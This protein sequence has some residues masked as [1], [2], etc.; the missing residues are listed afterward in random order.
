MKITGISKIQR[1]LII[2]ED[3]TYFD[4]KLYH[5]TTKDKLNEMIFSKSYSSKYIPIK[6]DPLK[7]FE[8]SFSDFVKP[9]NALRKASL[10]IGE[11]GESLVNFYKTGNSIQTAK[12]IFLNYCNQEKIK[13]EQITE[14]EYEFIN[15]SSIGALIYADKNY[16]GPVYEYDINSFYPSIMKC[17]KFKI[18][19][20]QGEI[21]TISKI[22]F[23]KMKSTFFNHGIY[24]CK[25]TSEQPNKLF[26]FNPLNYY[27]TQSIRHAK[28]L[29]LNIECIEE[30]D[31][32][33]YYPPSSYISG[34]KLFGYFV[35]TLFKLTKEHPKL[36]EFKEIL[37]CLWGL[38]SK[39]KKTK[40]CI[41][42]NEP[43]NIDLDTTKINILSQIM[44]GDKIYITYQYKTN[45][46]VYDF[47][48]IKTFLLSQGRLKLAEI[49]KDHVE[50]V[51]Q[52]QT[53]GFKSKI[54]LTDL[55]L[56]NGIG[57]LRYE[58][59]RNVKIIH[60]NKIVEI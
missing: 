33:L 32:F 40:I 15:N 6:K 35:D 8:Q 14:I 46:F 20:K 57:D 4:G 1:K 59:K 18:P 26:R 54:E 12:T 42:I 10:G 45:N 24:K 22:E 58:G 43:S 16:E 53:D 19:I 41:D 37:N 39:S 31:N 5:Q 50:N 25:I 44:E 55:K 11:N 29:N 27:T 60:V 3:I 36:K 51:M 21:K 34:N 7:T 13:T 38:L 23:D 9:A 2:Y 30:K 28:M 48:R 47:G 52:I 56:G 49:L 17:N